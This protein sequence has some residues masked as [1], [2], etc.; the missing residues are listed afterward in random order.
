MDTAAPRPGGTLGAKEPKTHREK[1]EL[2]QNQ[3]KVSPAHG[4]RPTR[5]ARGEREAHRRTA[6]TGE[7]NMNE[8]GLTMRP[9]WPSSLPDVPEFP[10]VDSPQRA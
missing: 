2:E 10:S 4:R 5:H 8:S 7:M 9:Q 1:P 3:Q 6:R